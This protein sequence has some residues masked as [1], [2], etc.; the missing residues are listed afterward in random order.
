MN[1]DRL[2]AGVATARTASTL[3]QPGMD[4]AAFHES[5]TKAE[6]AINSL[7][8]ASGVMTKLPSEE[9]SAIIPYVAPQGSV[10]KPRQFTSVYAPGVSPSGT[11]LAQD[12][13]KGDII[14]QKVQDVYQQQ[15]NIAESKAR[16][17]AGLPL[18]LKQGGGRR[19]RH[20]KRRHHAS[21][22]K[23]RRV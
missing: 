23:R 5:L 7:K 10:F 20:Q 9:E 1:I 8:A 14:T 17:I 22:H 19:T 15:A 12:R 18:L 3:F 11:R 13:L 21:T 16:K 4:V 6:E 2:K